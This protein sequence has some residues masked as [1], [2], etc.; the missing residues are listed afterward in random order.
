MRRCESGSCARNWWEGPGDG[1]LYELTVPLCEETRSR[2]GSRA[3]QERKLPRYD[4][5]AF[6]ILL[7]HNRSGG[8]YGT[9]G[10]NGTHGTC[11]SPSVCSVFSVCSVIPT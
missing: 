6:Y 2:G 3:L 10:K 9:D 8:D 4:L 5:L 11:E 1:R 7:G